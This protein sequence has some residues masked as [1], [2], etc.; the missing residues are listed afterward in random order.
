MNK[1]DTKFL[2]E[3]FPNVTHDLKIVASYCSLDGNNATWLNNSNFE[4]GQAA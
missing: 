3:F 2:I 1:N 4:V